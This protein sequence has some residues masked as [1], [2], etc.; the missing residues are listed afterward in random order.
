MGVTTVAR[1]GD[2]PSAVMAALS[3]SGGVVIE[4]AVVG[5]EVSVGVIGTPGHALPG[6]EIVPK[7]GRKGPEMSWRD[8]IGG[9]AELR[10]DLDVSVDAYRT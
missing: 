10:R 9:D 7:G 6:V 2:L 4:S 1:E 8:L 3:F 5:T